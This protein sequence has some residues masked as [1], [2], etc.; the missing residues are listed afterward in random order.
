M[1]GARRG[2]PLQRRHFDVLGAAGCAPGCHGQG[3]ECS[4]LCAGL[5]C[6]ATTRAP[7]RALR[8]PASSPCAGKDDVPRRR[9]PGWARRSCACSSADAGR[10]ERDVR[11]WGR[12]SVD[13]GS[14]GRRRERVHRGGARRGR[15]RGPARREEPRALQ[16]NKRQVWARRAQA[17]PC[18]ITR[19]KTSRGRSAG[20]CAACGPAGCGHGIWPHMAR[21]A[22]L[23][24]GWASLDPQAVPGSRWVALRSQACAG[25]PPPRCWCVGCCRPCCCCC[26]CQGSQC[27]LPRHRSTMGAATARRAT[28]GPGAAPPH[29]WRAGRALW[30][31]VWWR[32]PMAGASSF[33]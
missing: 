4:R 22:P 27:S 6:Q 12:P 10:G 21:P 5:G 24:G 3:L 1:G 13:H 29:S 14:A 2:G 20:G 32:S 8:G 9:A 11:G 31:Y 30:L 33:P 15:T 28:A 23:Y 19:I 7:G 18:V 25:R 26:C 16:H 17:G